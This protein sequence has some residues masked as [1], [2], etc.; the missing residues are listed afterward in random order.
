MIDCPESSDS[1]TPGVGEIL[2]RTTLRD[3]GHSLGSAPISESLSGWWWL[4]EWLPHKH[5]D[6]KSKTM[7]WTGP[8]FG[9]RRYIEPGSTVHVSVV[10]R[11]ND[12]TLA[13]HPGNLPRDFTIEQ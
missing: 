1:N 3:A 5:F 12:A 2:L 4:A 10:S 9:K 6:S 11:M 7:R 8:N 13:Y